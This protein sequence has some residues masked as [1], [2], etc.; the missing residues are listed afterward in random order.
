MVTRVN[1]AVLHGVDAALM[2]YKCAASDVNC[3]EAGCNKALA[4]CGKH[5][6]N[7]CLDDQVC[8]KQPLHSNACAEAFSEHLP[9]DFG[10]P[11]TLPR[12]AGESVKEGETSC[13][14]MGW[15]HNCLLVGGAPAR[16]Q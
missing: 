13:E 2:S 5:G 9:L 8:W 4:Y 15:Y 7:A 11:R 16:L 6:L 12:P 14:C 10:R 3:R 1:R